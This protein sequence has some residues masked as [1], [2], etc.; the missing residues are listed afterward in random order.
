MWEYLWLVKHL[1]IIGKPGVTIRQTG[2]DMCSDSSVAVISS[3]MNSRRYYIV[4]R[5][6][7]P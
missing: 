4:L 7:T 5:K 6:I 2:E 3:A 1:S